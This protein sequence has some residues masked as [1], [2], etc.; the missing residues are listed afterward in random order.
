M[1]SGVPEPYGRNTQNIYLYMSKPIERILRRGDLHQLPREQAIELIERELSAS[2]EETNTKL[3]GN[4]GPERM[5]Q[6]RIVGS[7]VVVGLF[8]AFVW[9]FIAIWRYFGQ[10]AVRSTEAGS[11]RRYIFGYALMAPVLLVTLGWM[12]LPLGW[13][14]V[15]AFTDYRLAIDSAFVGIDNFANVLYDADFWLSLMRTAYFVVLVIGLGFWPPILLAILLDEVPTAV[16]KY[17]FRTVFYLPAIISG[18]IIMFLWKQLYDPSEFGAL[19]QLLLSLNA[20]PAVAATLL[21][22]VMFGAWLSFLAVLAWL[23]VRMREMSGRMRWGLAVVGVA[24]T[25]GSVY[26]WVMGELNGWSLVGRF[27]L[28]PLDWVASPRLAMLCV[29]LPMVWAGSGPG[30]LLYLAALKTIP[31]DLYEAADLD[32]AGVWH[33]ICYITL[34]QLKYL[35]MIQFIAALVGAFKGGTDYILAMTGGGPGDSTMILALHIFIR[36]F[37]ELEFGIG[38]AMAWLL[39]ALLVGLTAYQLKMLSRAEFRAEG[40]G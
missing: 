16:L 13:G 3:L 26:P 39:G 23:P 21:K 36:T 4:I 34:P 22:W 20:L 11:S 9:G 2:A 25:V 33:K 28:Q 30:C 15:L 7:V 24:L 10:V 27:E 29:V 31:P 40:A 5:R 32:G 12:Y 38:T 1:D 14:F 37:M 18:V 19:N 6:R 35:I 17:V 8:T